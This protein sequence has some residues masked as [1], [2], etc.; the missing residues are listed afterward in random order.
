[1][2]PDLAG[3]TAFA[4]DVQRAAIEGL[5]LV[6]RIITVAHVLSA[7]SSTVARS[8][9]LVCQHCRATASREVNLGT[10]RIG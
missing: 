10:R 2:V 9:A 1:L 7:S 5:R 3:R 4:D 6:A 8:R